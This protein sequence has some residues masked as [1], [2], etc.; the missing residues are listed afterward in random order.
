VAQLRLVDL[1]FNNC[2]QAG[3]S[4]CGQAMSNPTT[5]TAAA[6]SPNDFPSRHYVLPFV[7]PVFLQQHT[8]KPTKESGRWR[9]PGLLIT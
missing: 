5:S 7:S 9:T 6:T 4:R 2:A 3:Y 1:T 8:S